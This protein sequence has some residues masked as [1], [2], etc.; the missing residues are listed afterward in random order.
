ML[1]TGCDGFGQAS[2][3]HGGKWNGLDIGELPDG[4]AYTRVRGSL[5][6]S[7]WNEKKARET[8]L[9]DIYYGAP[10]LST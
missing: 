4:H 2:S 3:R 10:R 7:P 6:L 8:F 1:L 5:S 9:I